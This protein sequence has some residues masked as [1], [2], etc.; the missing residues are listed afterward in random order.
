MGTRIDFF[1]DK[2]R[3][4]LPVQVTKLSFWLSLSAA[5]TQ[6]AVSRHVIEADTALLISA[7]LTLWG[8]QGAV[9]I[10][11]PR[12]PWTEAERAEWQ[13]LHGQKTMPP[14]MPNDVK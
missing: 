7:T 10:D 4:A 5:L 6:F 14:H 3:R 9:L 8:F 11:V 1:I 2:L 12:R 13:R